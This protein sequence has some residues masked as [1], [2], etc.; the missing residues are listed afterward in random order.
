MGSD[1]NQLWLVLGRQVNISTH[2]YP[3]RT[4]F[5][6]RNYPM[7]VPGGRFRESYYWDSWWIVRGLLV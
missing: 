5:V 4:S 1:L 7:I 6:P 3:Q 2:L